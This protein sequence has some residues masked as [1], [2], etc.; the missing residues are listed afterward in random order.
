MEAE[1]VPALRRYGIDILVYNGLAGGLFT[2]KYNAQNT[3]APKDIS[4]VDKTYRARYLR[5][6]PLEALSLVEPIVK[7]HNLTLVETAI[8]WLVHHSAL[9]MRSKGG[10]E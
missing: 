7:K 10:N 3:E 9:K 6:A 5:D 1:L 2:G 8:R 4:H